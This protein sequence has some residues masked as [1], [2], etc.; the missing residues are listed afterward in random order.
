MFE[1]GAGADQIGKLRVQRFGHHQQLGPA[2]RQHELIIVFR[3]KRIHR[4]RHDTGLEGAQEGGGPIDAVQQADQ[5]TLLA[6]DTQVMQDSAEA[7]HPFRQ[8]AVAPGAA[9]IDERG[10]AGPPGGEIALQNI[11]REI[12][13]RRHRADGRLRRLG[14]GRLC[15]QLGEQSHSP[16]FRE[17]AL[18]CRSTSYAATRFLAVVSRHANFPRQ[19]SR[20]RMDMLSNPRHEHRLEQGIKPV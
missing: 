7:L 18:L 14:G 9:P 3:K 10:L 13:L 16:P 4:H 12:V 5:D 15:T 1:I 19:R 17:H 2:V 6:L 20:M 8:R 11:G